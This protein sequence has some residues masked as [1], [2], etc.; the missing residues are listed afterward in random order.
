MTHYILIDA[1]T[2]APVPLP[3]HTTDKDGNE[4]T[5]YNFTDEDL[6]ITIGGRDYRSLPGLLGLALISEVDFMAERN[7]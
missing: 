7:Q 2:R 6:S 1:K 5:V 3:Y 4:V